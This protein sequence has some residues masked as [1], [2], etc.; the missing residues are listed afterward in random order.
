MAG[1]DRD[2]Q[3]SLDGLET[4][5]W[6]AD[7][8]D[9]D[10][11]STD[12]LVELMNAQDLTVPA[13]VAAAAPAIAAAIDEIAA[14]LR[15]GGRLIY[16]GAGTSG[17]LAELDAAECEATFS[18]RPSQVTALI[19]G[20]T[21]GSAL[22]QEAAEDDAAAGERELE[23]LDVSAADA[24]VAISASGRTPYVV[25]ALG[26]AAAAGALTVCLVSVRD[27]E[28]ARTA[29]HEIAV[30]VGAEILTGSTRLKAGTSQ[31]LVLN[32]IST[33]SMIRIGKTFGNLMVDVYPANEKLEARVRRI[34][35]L[36]TG[37][38]PERVDEAL[39]A[40]D[41]DPKVAIVSL[42]AGVDA[43]AARTRLAAAGGVVRQALQP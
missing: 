10:L 2:L 3:E 35:L 28:L 18:A 42:L 21:G 11:R 20:G 39:V 14:R 13:A 16:V 12:E 25:G 22:E 1:P 24:V 9:L 38:Q 41:G 5:T 43:A 8:A 30:P 23:A 36:A 37:A 27:S 29:Q 4:E 26:A 7:G 17:R 31:K 19:A 34:V 15:D 33:I 40:A 32:M 6:N